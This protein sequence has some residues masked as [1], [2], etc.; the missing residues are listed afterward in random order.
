MASGC[1]RSLTQWRKDNVF[2][3]KVYHGWCF[4]IGKRYAADASDT[5]KRQMVTHR[6]TCTNLLGEN[7]KYH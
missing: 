3:A 1:R 4:V 5:V 2:H 6:S 7:V